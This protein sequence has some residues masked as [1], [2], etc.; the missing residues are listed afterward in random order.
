ML[1]GTGMH[2]LRGKIIRK[3]IF[4]SVDKGAERVKYVKKLK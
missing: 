3:L 2:K 1:S 4:N